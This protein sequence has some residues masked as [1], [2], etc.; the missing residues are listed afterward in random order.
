[1]TMRSLYRNTVSVSWH[2]LPD[3]SHDKTFER[4]VDD[5]GVAV[6][7]DGGRGRDP[8]YVAKR[9]PKERELRDKLSRLLGRAPDSVRV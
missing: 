8:W 9:G 4:L 5:S 1:M 3:T 7:R 6:S 2:E